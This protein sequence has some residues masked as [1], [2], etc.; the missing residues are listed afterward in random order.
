MNIFTNFTF[1]NAKYVLI[2]ALKNMFICLLDKMNIFH[3]PIYIILNE[4][5]LKR[6]FTFLSIRI[7]LLFLILMPLSS[8]AQDIH[9]SQYY[10]S[11]AT[12]NPALT[13]I[14]RG[15]IRFYGTYRSQWNAA[16]VPYKTFHAAV[17]G[18]LFNPR[19]EKGFF[20]LGGQLYNDEAGDSN[21]SMNHVGMSVS[22]TL[23]LDSENFLTFG[24]SGGVSLRTFEMGG[25]TW[26]NQFAGDAFDPSRSSG[27]N[28]DNDTKVFPDFGAGVNWHGQKTG[29]RSRLD[30]GAAVYHFT[31]PD[32]SFY[33]N[34]KAKMP[35]RFS[36]YILPTLQINQNSDLVF[37]GT[38]QIQKKS[39]FE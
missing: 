21:L 35:M 27:E 20:S 10:N 38:A 4:H 12:L 30:V 14:F 23:A 29:K 32:Q 13:G 22:Y 6:Y 33:N 26:N 15:D 5:I 28:F 39:Y 17:D 3:E 11:P 9:F 37:H 34:D 2:C 7:V 18:K 19:N 16:L 8:L 1:V 31:Q 25:L 24:V 36:V